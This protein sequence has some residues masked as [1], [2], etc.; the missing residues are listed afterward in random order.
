MRVFAH[1]GNINGPE[2]HLENTPERIFQ[3]LKMGFDLETDIRKS[4]SGIF[5]ISHDRSIAPADHLATLHTRIWKQFPSALIALNIKELGYEA[6]L[7][8]FLQVENVLEQLFMFDMEMLEAVK[9]STAR[10]FRELNANIKLASRISDQNEPVDQALAIE[11]SSIIW[12]D[13]FHKLWVKPEIIRQLKDAGKS[14]YMISPE[15][16]G[17]SKNQRLH[18]WDDMLTWGVD[19]VCTDWPLEFSIHTGIR[20][21]TRD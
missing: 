2:P 11:P 18:R 10:L 9:G 17:F 5:Y 7:L 21:P 14:V 1:R 3:S 13:E 6:A 16:H 4:Q 8:D 12:V 15:I 19:G 20:Q